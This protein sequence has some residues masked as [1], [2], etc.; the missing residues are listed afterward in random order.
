MEVVKT[1]KT[2]EKEKQKKNATTLVK[3]IKRNKIAFL[4]SWIWALQE[5][6]TAKHNKPKQDE[7]QRTITREHATYKNFDKNLK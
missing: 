7:E 2:W 3:K 4:V 6:F 5:L 1:E